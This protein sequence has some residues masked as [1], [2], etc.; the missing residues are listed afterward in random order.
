MS[1]DL[2]GSIYHTPVIRSLLCGEMKVDLGIV[3]HL[4]VRMN[5]CNLYF[6]CILVTCVFSL[7]G[8]LAAFIIA[9]HGT[10]SIDL[11]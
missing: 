8:V 11:S 4:M 10:P 2:L 5:A 9:L 1:Q 3:K 6:W 7:S